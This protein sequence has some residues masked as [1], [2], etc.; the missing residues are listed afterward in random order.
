MV[1]AGDT[2]GIHRTKAVKSRIFLILFFV[3]CISLHKI[4]MLHIP[5]SCPRNGTRYSHKPPDAA[6]LGEANA[7]Q[8]LRT[9][10]R[11]EPKACGNDHTQLAHDKRM[12]C[13]TDL[14]RTNHVESA[15]QVISK[16]G[17]SMYA[18]VYDQGVKHT[19]IRSCNMSIDTLSGCYNR[20][21][22]YMDPNSVRRKT[23]HT[24]THTHTRTHK[25]THT[26]TNMHT[27]CTYV[28]RYARRG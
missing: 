13:A 20:F 26:H 3:S 24:L 1:F 18:H 16:E 22:L 28:Y 5:M 19:W 14:T 12:D 6:F 2:A 27:T 15:V 8:S 17:M 21:V 11:L 7:H 25:H 9:H 4:S 23:T 10:K